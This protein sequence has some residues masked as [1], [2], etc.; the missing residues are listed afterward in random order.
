MGIAC[1]G[2]Q[3]P[4]IYYDKYLFNLP[5]TIGVLFQLALCAL[6]GIG[7]SMEPDVLDIIYLQNIFSRSKTEHFEDKLSDGL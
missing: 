4:S 1:F 3:C 6:A 2:D 5:P 7:F